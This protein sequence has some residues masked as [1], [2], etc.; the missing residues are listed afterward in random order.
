M[1]SKLTQVRRYFA[2]ECVLVTCRSGGACRFDRNYRFD[3]LALTADVIDSVPD[4]TVTVPVRSWVVVVSF[5]AA[6]RP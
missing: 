2:S 5:V 3:E 4:L 6:V 1:E